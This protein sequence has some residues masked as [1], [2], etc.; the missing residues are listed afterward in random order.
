M[1]STYVCCHLVQQLFSKEDLVVNFLEQIGCLRS[2][3][4]NELNISPLLDF[5]PRKR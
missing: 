1:S 4:L 5:E 3:I 2:D